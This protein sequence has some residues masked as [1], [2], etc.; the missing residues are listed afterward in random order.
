MTKNDL[1][2]AAPSLGAIWL[3]LVSVP[4]EKWASITGFVFILVQLAHKVWTWR[5][6]RV[7][8][9]RQGLP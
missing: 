3:Y 7:D 4:V 9:R 8:R 2:A 1:I 6:E 5:N